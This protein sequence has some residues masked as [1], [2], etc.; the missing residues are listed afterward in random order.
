MRPNDRLLDVARSSR[1]ITSEHVAAPKTEV[2][3]TERQRGV[4][5]VQRDQERLAIEA[6]QVDVAAV[7]QE[8]RRR[9]GMAQPGMAPPRSPIRN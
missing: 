2:A 8:Y 4:V 9:R 7:V 1:R 3:Q 5:D 6:A